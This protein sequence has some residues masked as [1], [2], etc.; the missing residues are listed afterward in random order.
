MCTLPEVHQTAE[1]PEQITPSFEVRRPFRKRVKRTR[2][3]R[4]HAAYGADSVLGEGYAYFVWHQLMGFFTGCRGI[5]DNR[6]CAR[7]W[8][9]GHRSFK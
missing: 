5:N 2:A 4:I 9:S 7:M 6:T 3:T 1:H 8:R